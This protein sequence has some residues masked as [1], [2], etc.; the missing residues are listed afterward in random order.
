MRTMRLILNGKASGDP[1]L[2][3]AV[4]QIR[5]QGH[6]LDVRVT[7]EAGDAARYAGEAV[8]DGVQAVLAGGGDGTINEIVNGLLAEDNQRAPAVGLVPFGTANDFATACGIPKGDPLGALRL[9]AEGEPRPIDVGKVNHQYFINVTSGGFGAEVTAS[10]PPEMK[11]ALGGAAYSLMGLVTAAKMSPYRG[12]LV[13]SEG[14]RAGQMILCAVGNGRQAGG[15]FPV[16]PSALLNDGLLD[17]MV[18]HDVDLLEL[19]VLFSELSN[20]ESPDNK[21]VSYQQLSAFRI[22]AEQDLQLNLDG[23]PMRGRDFAFS[24]LPQRL[25]FILPPDIPLLT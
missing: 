9:A 14:E 21:Y 20:M 2:R 18:V 19:G 25:S 6:T 15:G 16:C 23:E 24:V 13:T 10:T 3:D 17:L 8:R 12:K 4:G 11:K 22:E 7:W 5:E 1:A